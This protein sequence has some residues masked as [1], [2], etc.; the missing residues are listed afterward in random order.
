[1]QFTRNR[2]WQSTQGIEAVRRDDGRVVPSLGLWRSRGRAGA[3]GDVI[4]M[5]NEMLQVLPPGGGMQV[6]PTDMKF[7]RVSLN[8]RR[9]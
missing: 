3:Y 2:F 8:C 7:D 4:T 5:V 9:S 1:M 6:P